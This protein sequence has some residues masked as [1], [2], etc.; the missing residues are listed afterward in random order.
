MC[1]RLF[2]IKYP[3]K[4]LT[5]YWIEIDTSKNYKTKNIN[6]GPFAFNIDKWRLKL[7]LFQIILF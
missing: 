4:H 3:T 6:N 7:I 5:D 2:N 1:S